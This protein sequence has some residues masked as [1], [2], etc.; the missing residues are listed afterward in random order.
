RGVTVFVDPG[1]GGVDPGA[2]GSTAGGT[3]VEEKN[4][5]LAVG[6]DLLAR[7]RSD[8]YRV[9]MSRTRD[10]TVAPLG[11]A[12]VGSGGL[13]VAAEHLD[14]EA[15]VDCANTS[16]ARLLV[17]IHMNAFQDPSV[18]G[19]ETVYDSA[20]PFSASSARF[21]AAVQK[22]VVAALASRGWTVADRGLKDDSTLDPPTHSVQAENYGHLLELGPPQAGWLAHPSL[23]PGALV[24]PLFV[25]DPGEAALAL[26]PRCQGA[27]AAALQAA[28][29]TYF[30]GP[31]AAS[32]QG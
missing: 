12:S 26:D 13:T 17:S 2:V 6:L 22:D 25:T 19:T 29:D 27:V 30:T 4:V 24:E 15:R 23:M 18:G 28:V 31:A 9:V 21:A 1:H 32:T 11:P 8:G 5:T 7:L 10:T 16:G 14:T 20:R 3:P